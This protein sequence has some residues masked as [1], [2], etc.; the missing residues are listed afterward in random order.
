MVHGFELFIFLC[1][2]VLNIHDT[3]MSV[4]GCVKKEI[5]HLFVVMNGIPVF[6]SSEKQ[7][8]YCN[9]SESD[10]RQSR[11]QFLLVNMCLQNL[12]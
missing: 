6:C 1:L 7:V 9:W 4:L 3:I 11:R 2:V 5:S 12:L 8:S 10:I